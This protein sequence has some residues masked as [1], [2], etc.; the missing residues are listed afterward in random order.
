MDLNEFFKKSLSLV[1]KQ[2][3]ERE[4]NKAEMKYASVI[5]SKDMLISD[6]NNKIESIDKRIN[7]ILDNINTLKEDLKS[8][9]NVLNDI[10][11]D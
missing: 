6:F 3:I 9:M 10:E 5:A 7:E 2:D 4:F 11:E 8:I 1:D